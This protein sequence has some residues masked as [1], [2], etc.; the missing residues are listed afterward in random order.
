MQEPIAQ[1]LSRLQAPIKLPRALAQIQSVTESNRHTVLL[2]V[3]WAEA[4][5]FQ[6]T[7]DLTW[8][9]LTDNTHGWTTLIDL[10]I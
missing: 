8:H 1:S 9:C 2:A 7:T 4:G 6:H 5:I 10:A 3:Q